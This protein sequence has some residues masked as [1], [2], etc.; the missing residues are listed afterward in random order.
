[1][2]TQKEKKFPSNFHQ[3]FKD[4]S[5]SF[6][7]GRLQGVVLVSALQVR[8]GSVVEEELGRFKPVLLFSTLLKLFLLVIDALGPVL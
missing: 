8:V 2:T 7:A 4:F 3:V 6:Q 5:G 1:M